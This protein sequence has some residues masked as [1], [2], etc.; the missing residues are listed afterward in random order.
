MT[1]GDEPP[2][3]VRP[4]RPRPTANDGSTPTLPFSISES[5]IAGEP[6]AAAVPADAEGAVAEQPESIEGREQV[7]QNSVP[8]AP[9]FDQT[10]RGA[11]DFD[12]DWELPYADGSTEPLTRRRRGL[13]KPKREP[14]SFSLEQPASAIATPNFN[15]PQ[16]QAARAAAGVEPV[17]ASPHGD[18][19]SAPAQPL[20]REPTGSEPRPRRRYLALAGLLV[21]V[22]AAATI[23]GALSRGRGAGAPAAATTHHQTNST[24]AGAAKGTLP[25]T[26]AVT[27][28]KRTSTAPARKHKPHKHIATNVAGPDSAST[29]TTTSA[30]STPPTRSSNDTATST[31]TQTKT[32]TSSSTQTSST[33]P[34]RGGD[35]PTPAQANS[36]P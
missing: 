33:Q 1:N 34:W 19:W 13:R 5:L 35:L 14:A 28:I 25:V 32:P 16:S 12:D 36:A 29:T 8:D 20:S 31:S 24:K 9:E 2:N 22:I 27:T 17:S 15:Q 30:V 7:E 3:N 6:G 18:D 10:P 26:R 21:A 11:D 23:T 4:L